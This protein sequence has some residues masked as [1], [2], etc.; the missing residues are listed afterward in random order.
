MINLI[1]VSEV[2]FWGS[3][4]KIGLASEQSIYTQREVRACR[5]MGDIVGVGCVETLVTDP[6]VDQ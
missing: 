4:C 6:A 1:Y 3:R 2:N 5:R